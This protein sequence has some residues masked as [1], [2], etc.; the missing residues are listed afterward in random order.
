MEHH[1]AHDAEEVDPGVWRHRH[2]HDHPSHPRAHEGLLEHWYSPTDGHPHNH[3]PAR[4]ALD[5]HHDPPADDRGAGP[6]P[7]PDPD[8]T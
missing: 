3:D 6:D 2:P 1:R 7:D 4:P 8:P 5:Q